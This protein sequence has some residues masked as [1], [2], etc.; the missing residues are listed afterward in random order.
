[1]TTPALPPDEEH[2][3]EG[4]GFRT[5]VRSEA[6]AVGCAV[7]V[8]VLGT[9]LLIIGAVIFAGEGQW[10]FVLGLAVLELLFIA[11]FV[12]MLHMAKQRHRPRPD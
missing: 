9:V 7:F 8:L 3:P 10:G 4:F 11:G 2:R 6:V 1:M 5:G 12:A